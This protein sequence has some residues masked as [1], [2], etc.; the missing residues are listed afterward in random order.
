MKEKTVYVNQ[1]QGKAND[2][3]SEDAP[4]LTRKRAEQIQRKKKTQ[5]LKIVGRQFQEAIS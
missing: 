5:A 3:L 2:G 4:V 1:W